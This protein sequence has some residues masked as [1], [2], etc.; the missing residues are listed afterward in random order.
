MIYFATTAEVIDDFIYEIQEFMNGVAHAHTT[1]LHKID[2]F[3]IKA[4]AHG[5]PL[6]FVNVV[7]R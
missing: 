7:A 6:I 3:G 1:L 5:T 4:V 2:V